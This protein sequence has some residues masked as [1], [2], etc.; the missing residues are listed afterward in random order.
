M[1]NEDQVVATQGQGKRRRSEAA[2]EEAEE[3]ELNL[4]QQYSHYAGDT[5]A[6]EAAVGLPAGPP[7]AFLFLDT[8]ALSTSF[9]WEEDYT[10]RVVLTG[11][12]CAG[13][14]TAL[15]MLRDRLRNLGWTVVTAP[16]NATL[17]FTAI[18]GF[19][20]RWAEQ[21]EKLAQMQAIFLRAQIAMED[22]L[23]ALAKMKG[24]KVVLLCDRG[25]LD[26]R[27]FLEDRA[28]ESAVQQCGVTEAELRD[29][30]YDMIVHMV[31]AASGAPEFYEWGPGS[32]NP[33]R[34]HDL[35]QAAES[36]RRGQ[37]SYKGH[38]YVRVIDNST[39]FDRKVNQA[40]PDFFAAPHSRGGVESSSRCTSREGL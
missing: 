20:A 12:P 36:C 26:G 35:E 14:S 3:Y 27:M 13:K 7:S 40:G 24:G 31:T 23:L 21:E 29:Q 25:A 4:T 33:E 9:L 11:G 19:D 28:W 22:N 8:H 1:G 34:F 6:G 37:E 39:G 2:A 38:P 16:E 15:S 17:L 30:R 10:Y 32:K 18:G 5:D